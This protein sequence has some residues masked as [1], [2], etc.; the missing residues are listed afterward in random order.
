MHGELNPRWKG[1]ISRKKIAYKKR[2][3]AKYPEKAKAHD[4]VRRAKK[5]GVLIPQPC[6]D[7][8]AKEG[9]HAHHDDYSKVLVVTWLCPPCHRKRH[10]AAA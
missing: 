9:V 2:F 8:G 5:R 10:G 4:A 6:V 1:G 3:R 7:C